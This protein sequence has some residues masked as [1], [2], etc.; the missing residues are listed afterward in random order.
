VVITSSHW[1]YVP[2]PRAIEMPPVPDAQYKLLKAGIA[3]HG[4]KQPIPVQE[5]TN[6]LLDGSQRL[7]ACREL[8]LPVKVMPI[9]ISDDDVPEYTAAF[10]SKHGMTPTQKALAALAILPEFE[11]KAKERQRQGSAKLR[12]GEK[13][14]ATAEAAK[15]VGAKPRYVE[16]AL[17]LKREDAEVYERVWRGELTISAG[18]TEA[19]NKKAH[20]TRTKPPKRYPAERYHGRKIEMPDGRVRHLR[21]VMIVE[22]RWDDGPDEWERV[23]PEKLQADGGKL[24]SK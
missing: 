8:N 2:H 24:V 9:D 21:T 13:G 20:G 17:Q 3:A 22:S 16:L 4:L 7:R 1:D 6:F 19:K 5:G 12:E 23:D 11:A 18:I 14:K 10:A 15:L